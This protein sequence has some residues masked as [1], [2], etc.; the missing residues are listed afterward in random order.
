MRS[1]F[2]FD[3]PDA[4]GDQLLIQIASQLSQSMPEFGSLFRWAPCAFVTLPP[5]STA[6]R[7]LRSARYFR[8]Q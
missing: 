1:V 6:Y 5:T 4:R 2:Q 8:L 7:A 3:V